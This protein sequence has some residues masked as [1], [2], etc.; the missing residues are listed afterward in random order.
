MSSIVGVCV[1]MFLE[2]RE[3]SLSR[4]THDF[5]LLTVPDEKVQLVEN[6]LMQLYSELERDPMW[7]SGYLGAVVLE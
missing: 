6:F 7:I 3:Q 4:F 2:R 1:R 5:M